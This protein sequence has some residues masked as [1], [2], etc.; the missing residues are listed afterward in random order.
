[1]SADVAEA[2]V[3]FTKA[4]AEHDCTYGDACQGPPGWPEGNPVRHGIC[5]GCAARRALG[6]PA[7]V[8]GD[9]VP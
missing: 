9:Y 4:M 5:T 3:Q 8:T 7:S 2:A 1:M 6:L